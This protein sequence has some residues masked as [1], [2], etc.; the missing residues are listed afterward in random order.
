MASISDNGRESGDLHNHGAALAAPDVNAWFVREVL[1]LEAGLK[2][3]LRYGWHNDSDLEDMCQD[4]FVRT[5]EAA[6]TQIPRPAKPF[7]F[8]IARNLLINR[9]RREQIVS[10]EA[11]ADLEEFGIPSDEPG[12]DRTLIARQE[13]KRLR[14]ALERLPQRWRDAVVMR[15]IDG[16]SRQEIAARMGL[17][18]STVAQH[19]ASG[20]DALVEEFHSERADQ[21]RLP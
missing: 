12:P 14:A 17:A 9:L 18:E 6:R 8:S 13:L 21:R 10:M 3:F 7:V 15:K 19:L 4:V 1:P 16:L 2:R 11:V 5:Y 20:I